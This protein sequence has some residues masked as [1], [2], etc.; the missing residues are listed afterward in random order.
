M[1]TLF[2]YDYETF[3]TD[4][5]RDRI[6]QFAGLRTDEELQ[7]IGEP[8]L[9]DVLTRFVQAVGVA[10]R[11]KGAASRASHPRRISRSVSRGK[12][13]ARAGQGSGPRCAPALKSRSRRKI[14]RAHV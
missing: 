10:P 9:D 13:M 3:G 12:P 2:W 1:N 14:G 8:T 6:A 4:P 7:V 11:R 5:Q